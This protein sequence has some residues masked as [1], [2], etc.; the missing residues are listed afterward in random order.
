MKRI[1]RVLTL[2]LAVVM[3]AVMLASCT[4]PPGTTTTSA[5]ATAT[6]KGASAA[7]SVAAPTTKGPADELSYWLPLATDKVTPIYTNYAQAP[8]FQWIMEATNTKINFVHPPAGQEK[9][10]FSL[11]ISSGDF[12]DIIEYDF[13][14]TNNYPGGADKAVEDGV[15]IAL[16][17]AMEKGWT[18]NLVAYFDKH[19]EWYSQWVSDSGNYV[20]FPFIREHPIL[21]SSWGPQVR[22]D[23]LEQ[24]NLGFGEKN[25]PNT[26]A[27][28]DQILRAFK[29]KGPAEY[30]LLI[31]N[32]DGW[33][34]NGT[35]PGAYGVGWEWYADTSSTLQY[36]PAQP[37]FRDYLTQMR[38]W[39]KDGLVDPDWVSGVNTEQLRSKI[40]GNKV[41]MYFTNVG[42]GI[43]YLYDTTN[44][45]NG[46][47]SAP[48]HPANFRSHGIPQPVLNEGEK[49]HFGGSALAVAGMN[50]FI[51]TD[52]KN[53]QAACRLL[54]YGYG[55]EGDIVYNFGKEGE[56]FKYVPYTDFPSVVD[57]SE[58]GDK[59]P[60]WIDEVYN[61]SPTGTAAGFPLAVSL[62]RFV[63]S[64]M[65]GPF[66][67]DA[68]YFVQFLPYSDSL[69]TV[70]TWVKS[71][72]FK[73]Q[74]LPRIYFKSDES[75][76]LA[77]IE[78]D[79]KTYKDE[80]VT[81]FLTGDLPI[82]DTSWQTF[83]DTLKQMGVEKILE[84][85]RT[86]YERAK[87]RK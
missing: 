59:F 63:R 85:R 11:M 40:L 5:A 1:S 42:G 36:G 12:P 76:Q 82:D 21:W 47:K 67:Q 70:D 55:P 15:I 77:A 10:N 28:W 57:L 73:G 18:P 9:E 58:W 30:P 56:S 83:Q 29:A 81:K 84:I 62:T 2:P 26:I 27:E 43:G 4:T 72:D 41:A 64:H 87:A 33:G 23:W 44:A 7:P 38:T 51:S 17:D 13:T 46:T 75:S 79:L 34:D 86:A 14:N 20:C 3:L 74:L 8:M 49:S 65:G 24:L 71:S 32:L 66:A 39:Y 25:L 37:A 31:V 6:T 35:L 78:S 50:C 61:P 22:L 52:C 68:G 80:T 69:S 45:T 60:R 48:N 16:N 54:D 53:V 19:P